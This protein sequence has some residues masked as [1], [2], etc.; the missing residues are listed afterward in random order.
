MLDDNTK[1]N[2]ADRVP[3][4]LSHDHELTLGQDRLADVRE[5]LEDSEQPRTNPLITIHRILRGKYL[6][7]GVLGLIL[8]AIAAAA[9]YLALQPKYVSTGT[10][11]V[12]ANKENILYADQNDAR[13]RLFDAFV[14]NEV[15]YLQSRPVLEQAVEILARDLVEWQDVEDGAEKLKGALEVKRN[16]GLISL[17]VEHDSAETAA[18][19]VNAI[20]EAYEELHVAQV[21]R[22]D[23]VREETLAA[24]EQELLAGISRLD[25]EILEVGEEHGA[26]SIATAHIRKIAQVEEVDVRIAELGTTI[27]SRESLDDEV[28]VDTGDDEIQRLLVLDHAMADMLKERTLRR[29]E[30]AVLLTRHAELHPEVIKVKEG[31]R[32]VDIAIEDRRQ[33]LATLGT[34]GALTK[35]NESSKEDSLDDLKKL[36]RR[37]QQR[38]DELRGD[39]R[40]LNEK[41]IRLDFLQSER[42]EILD[43]LEETRRALQEVRLES[44]NTLP[45]IVEVTVRGNVP[46]SPSGDKRK[47]FGAAGGMAGIGTGIAIVLLFGFAFRRFRCSDELDMYQSTGPLIGALETQRRGDR[48]Q[49]KERAFHQIRNELQLLRTSSQQPDVIAVAGTGPQSGASTVAFSLAQAFAA[50]QQK[51]VLIDCDLID[52][53]LSRRLGIESQAGLREALLTDHLNG[54]VHTTENPNLNVLP[55]GCSEEITDERM[56]VQSLQRLLGGLRR[57]FDVVVVDV[58]S[59]SDR[60]AARIMVS[61]ADQFV[62]VCRNR[63]RV[64]MVSRLVN[65]LSKISAGQVAFVFN[66]AGKR[67][68]T[69]RSMTMS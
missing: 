20:L 36:H 21:R 33:Q 53:S 27:A 32:I 40:I 23:Q 5:F 17:T 15:T 43:L 68:P 47:M 12:S 42:E 4:S 11:R 31:I 58:G 8:G 65:Q 30:L 25:S 61:I 56:S 2:Q 46:T 64:S 34:T 41:L 54:E 39:A 63:D 50:T 9:G 6:L 57:E 19:M 60:L 69:L 22:Q 48:K 51:T 3:D 26:H 62:L 28:E 29:A 24:R 59:L 1:S 13:L 45:G 52:A 16:E 49:P 44:R 18:Q 55:A 67:D 66:F 7:A 35:A 10:I 14:T 37:L 38:R